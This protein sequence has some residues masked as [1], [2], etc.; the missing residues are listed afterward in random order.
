MSWW[1][2][3]YVDAQDLYARQTG[4]ARFVAGERL[5]DFGEVR[6]GIEAEGLEALGR[7]GADAALVWLRARHDREVEGSVLTIPGLGP[8]EWRVEQWDTV[9][10]EAREPHTLSSGP[11]NLR[12][13]LS[14]FRRD[15][16]L[17]IRR[18]S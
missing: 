18:V 5:S 15:T 17:K 14:P 16:A 8:G 1:W 12:V 9:R 10:G 3:R 2:D 6:V 4:A 13:T 11:D 7:A